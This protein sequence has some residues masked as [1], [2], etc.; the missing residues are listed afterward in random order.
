MY[1]EAEIFLTRFTKVKIWAPISQ[2]DPLTFHGSLDPSTN[3]RIT[4][5]GA[6]MMKDGYLKT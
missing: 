4:Y 5:H 1:E 6:N 2:S 3:T